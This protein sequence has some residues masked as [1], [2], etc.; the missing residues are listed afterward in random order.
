MILGRIGFTRLP[1]PRRWPNDAV[2]PV[3]IDG[4]RNCPPEDA[5][6]AH[7][8]NACLDG[9]LEWLDDSYDPGRFDKKEAVKR[10]NKL[11]Y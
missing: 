2:V 7:G 9:E 10:L 3:L 4:T 1:S 8:Y 11:K 5:G 6:G